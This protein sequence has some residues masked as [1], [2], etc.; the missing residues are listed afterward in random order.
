MQIHS[1]YF[2]QRILRLENKSHSNS[3]TTEGKTPRSECLFWSTDC[4]E[5]KKKLILIFFIFFF[6]EWNIGWILR[7][8]VS[9]YLMRTWVTCLGKLKNFHRE[10]LWNT[11]KYA[12]V[13]KG[14]KL[15]EK[16]DTWWHH[17]RWYK[18][19]VCATWWCWGSVKENILGMLI[20]RK[21]KQ[22]RKQSEDHWENTEEKEMLVTRCPRK[23]KKKR[24][25]KETRL[26]PQEFWF[27]KKVVVARL[28]VNFDE[29]KTCICGRRSGASSVAQ[30]CSRYDSEKETRRCE[31]LEKI[32]EMA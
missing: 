24:K 32:V 10:M 27:G 2:A 6:S 11:E 20:R 29:M 17:P 18:S 21:K 9:S 14:R 28:R 7:L 19:E 31:Q 8:N 3:A 23:R 22:K 13:W 25:K 30:E 4:K 12:N 15:N 1:R 26:I 5:V 16:K